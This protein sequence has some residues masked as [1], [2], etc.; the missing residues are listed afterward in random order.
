MTGHA[1]IAATLLNPNNFRLE[2]SRICLCRTVSHPSVM[3]RKYL[4]RNVFHHYR[5]SKNF[6]A[7]ARGDAGVRAG[8]PLRLH[9]RCPAPARM[10]WLVRRLE[11]G[12]GGG[13]VIE[14]A[15]FWTGMG[16]VAGRR[17]GRHGRRPRRSPPD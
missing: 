14:C 9:A 15:R 1:G 7:G 5:A 4:R 12:S 16:R 11:E 6:T 8:A 13:E 2:V 17:A 10:G 3:P